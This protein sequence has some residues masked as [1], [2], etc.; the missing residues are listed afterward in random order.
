MMMK[1]HQIFVLQMI[2][3]FFV[4]NVHM[5]L[6]IKLNVLDGDDLQQKHFVHMVKLH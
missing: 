6:K 2:M 5:D 1:I 4:V 3:V